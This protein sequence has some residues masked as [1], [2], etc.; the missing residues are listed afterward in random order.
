MIKRLGYAATSGRG[1]MMEAVDFAV[2]N[3][4][5]W[6]ELSLNLPEFFPE[7]MAPAQWARAGAHAAVQGIGLTA[8]APEDLSLIQLHDGVRRAGLER[9]TQIMDWAHAVGVTRL[10]VHI[11]TSVYFTLPQGRQYLHQV[12]P[13]RFRTI[14]RDSLERLRD[15]AVGKVI[16][17]IENVAYF[18]TDVVQEVLADLLP[19]GGLYLTW[20]W[21]HSFGDPEQELFMRSHVH[22]VR[23]C[24]VHDHNG[25]QDHLVVGDGMMDLAG[26]AA[27]VQDLNCPLIFEVRPRELAVASK[28]RFLEAGLHLPL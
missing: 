21:G 6:V 8:H 4:F 28:K 23:N 3:D 25:K 1:G 11:G 9:M 27:A 14:L 24:H 16:V 12:Y 2:Q 7:A 20:D 18:G 17:C 19:Q 15:H 22:Y 26:Y 5:S 10:T 13:D